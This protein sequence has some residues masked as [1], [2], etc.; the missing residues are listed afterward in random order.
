MGMVLSMGNEEHRPDRGSRFFGRMVACVCVLALLLSLPASALAQ[1]DV[2]F[3]ASVDRTSVTSDETVTLELTLSGAFRA[4]DQPQI[5]PLEGFAVVGTSQ[6]S[7]FSMVNGTV[8]TRVSFVYRLQPTGT[9]TLTVPAIPITVGG[10][11]YRT[12][13]II[14]EVTQGGTPRSEGP[15]LEAPESASPPGE[16]AGQDL[17]VE[18]GVDVG[19]PVVGQ[20]T[21]YYFRL[22][23]AVQLSG[24]PHLDWPDFSGF[25]SYDLT[26]NLQYY[27]EVA[28]RRYLVTEVRRALFPTTPGIVPLGPS[29]LTVPGGFFSRDMVLRT[30][31]VEV[32]VRSLPEGKP[33]G[34]SGLVGEFSIEAHVEPTDGK[35]N[36]PVTLS[37]RVHGVGNVS[38]AVDPC[39][40]DGM[41]L[42]DWRVFDPQVTTS[43]EQEGDRI[44]GEKLFERPLVP[45]TDGE[46]TIPGFGLDF[47]DP[48]AGE[49]RHVE[50]ESLTVRV[51]AGEPQT[52]G[53]M[54]IGEGKHDVMVLT[55]DIRHIKPA[56]PSLSLGGVA[57]Y[58]RPAYWLAWIVSSAAVAGAWLWSQRRHRLG[59]DVGYHRAQRA[60]RVARRRLARVGRL[61]PSDED[62]A[63][64]AIAG[65]LS[66]YL[67]DKF[68]LPVAGLTRSAVRAVLDAASVPESL[69]GRCLDSLDWAD[70]GR[71]APVAA[72]RKG[73]ELI[74]E[75]E[76]VIAE[77]EERI[78]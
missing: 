73:A 25:M 22:Y 61:V 51:E 35:V 36:E 30:E 60:R 7:Q 31:S 32:D 63:Y 77:L 47:F 13:P 65:A 6:S 67:A 53:P 23:Q 3:T 11:T 33:E 20:Q 49:Y 70:S 39:G 34:F 45:K 46:L 1:D 28:G 10:R 14:V 64:A 57:L 43:V 58:S 52:P 42:P 26:P 12:Q 78:A 18:A 21:V 9:G 41:E 5:P 54:I 75:V 55:S 62:A 4:S 72:G 40:G 29:V 56:P 48:V 27:E 16:L 37:V 38:L 17:C 50:T 76:Q 66:S 71:F 74:A 68:N 59:Q 44:R 2:S 8:S 24:Q 19:S 69:V 15:T